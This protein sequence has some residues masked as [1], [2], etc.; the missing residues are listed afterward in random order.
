MNHVHHDLRVVENR[1]SRSVDISLSH[2]VGSLI[3][4]EKVRDLIDVGDFEDQNFAIHANFHDVLLVI[5]SLKNVNQIHVGVL[6]LYEVCFSRV[7]QLGRGGVS[8][9]MVMRLIS[10]AIQDSDST[11]FDKKAYSGTLI[12]RISEEKVREEETSPNKRSDMQG[13]GSIGTEENRLIDLGDLNDL[14]DLDQ[15]LEHHNGQVRQEV[16]I[17]V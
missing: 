8:V 9:E 5:E 4:N 14:M 17:A 16:L 12:S 1:D 13:R 2:F 3:V 7:V 11:V 6:P 15:S 10:L